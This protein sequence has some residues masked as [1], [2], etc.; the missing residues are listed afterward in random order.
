M[1]CHLGPGFDSPH[2]HN[3][4]NPARLFSFDG[5]FLYKIHCLTERSSLYIPKQCFGPALP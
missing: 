1:G 3:K 4:P 2:L 5:V